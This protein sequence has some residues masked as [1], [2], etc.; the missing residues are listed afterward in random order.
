MRPFRHP[1]ARQRLVL[2]LALA[3]GLVAAC[4]R[5]EGGAG[6]ERVVASG[7]ASGVRFH[8]ATEHRLYYTAF[9]RVYVEQGL[10]LWAACIDP[11]TC[12]SVA[13]GETV[14]IPVSAIHG[15]DDE[16]REARVY[17]WRLAPSPSGGF[18]AADMRSVV[19]EP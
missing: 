17:Y 11:D 2:W 15:W 12:P 10:F 5:T 14:T 13:P 7:D 6:P 4:A 1:R 8:N 16:A 19:V 9:E 3:F 18:E